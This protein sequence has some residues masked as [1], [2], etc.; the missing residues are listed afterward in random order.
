MRYDDYK[1]RIAKIA[2]VFTWIKRHAVMLSVIFGVIVTL[3][4]VSIAL[5]GTVLYSQYPN[6]Q[7]TYGDE[8]SP[9]A[10]AF[11]SRASFEYREENGEW[12]DVQPKFPG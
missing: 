6:E 2:R 10:F 11:L 8:I 7:V 1:N 9:K 5:K 4:G 3:T 12:T